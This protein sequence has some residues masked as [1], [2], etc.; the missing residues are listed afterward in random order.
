MPARVLYLEKLSNDIH[1]ETKIFQG[2]TKFKQYLS[3][4]LELQRILEEKFLH[5]MA[6]YTKGGR[7]Q[8]ITQLTK[9]ITCT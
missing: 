5:K 8:D 3:T 4:N 1:E 9:R 2:K 7:G 6:S